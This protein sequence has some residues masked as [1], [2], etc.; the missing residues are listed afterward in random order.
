M[1]LQGKDGIEAGFAQDFFDLFERH[2]Q[3][4][5]TIKSAASA[6]G[7]PQHSSDSRSRPPGWV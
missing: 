4:R 5:D 6:A 3:K 1:A 2:I 7:F